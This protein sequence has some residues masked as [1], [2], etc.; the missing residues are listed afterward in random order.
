[1]SH[2]YRQVIPSVYSHLD[3]HSHI[4]K[5]RDK[6]LCNISKTDSTHLLACLD[7]F[8][9]IDINKTSTNTTEGWW[10]CTVFVPKCSWGW[11][12]TKMPVKECLP[13][14]VSSPSPHPHRL[15]R[16]IMVMKMCVSVG[17]V[18][19]RACACMCVRRQE[20]K[21]V[22]EETPGWVSLVKCSI[23]AQRCQSV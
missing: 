1:M 8:T 14:P 3:I 6:F 15:M 10:D 17:E 20:W 21:A 5:A 18:D 22:L 13:L 23:C 16:Q 7:W 4:Y 19:V 2:L 9:K 11:V 12:A